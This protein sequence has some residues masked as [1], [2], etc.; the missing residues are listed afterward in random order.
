M[1]KSHGVYLFYTISQQVFAETKL[2]KIFWFS[3][4]LM[5]TRDR[6]INNETLP[7][8]EFSDLKGYLLDGLGQFVHSASAYLPHLLG[9]II[10]LIL[11]LAFAWIAKWI[12]LRLGAGID[13]VVHAIGFVS[14]HTRLKWPVAHIL[15]WLV[16]WIIILL[17]IRAA[18]AILKLPSLAE[19]LGKLLTYLP[20]LFIAG[21]FIVGGIM[22][23]NFVRN[24]ITESANVAGLRQAGALGGLAR[25][26]II[27]LSVVI[28][29][30]QIG[31]DV[32]LFEGILIIF[33]AAI[34]GSIALAFGLGAGSTV[35]NIISARYV[36][37]NYQIGQRISIQDM[38]GKILEILP[39]GIVLETKTGKTFIP[40][41]IFDQEASVLLDNESIDD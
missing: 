7:M 35:S 17:F 29:L 33:V 1:G 32:K 22:L 31:L 11:G 19:V 40:A 39:T 3:Y 30:A 14:L 24:K 18:F 9:A 8:N 41:K 5:C 28:G 12:I 2:D 16:Y 23:G 37:R 20:N 27:A 34:A 26:G 25:A 13:R 15:G 10:L 36:R 38:Q 21:L 6:S 4:I